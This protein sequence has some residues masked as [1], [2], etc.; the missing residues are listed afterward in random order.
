M[1]TIYSRSTLTIIA[2]TAKSVTEGFLGPRGDFIAASTRIPFLCR[3]GTLGTVALS[4]SAVS[5]AYYPQDNPIELRAWT[6][7][8]RLLA[9]R[10]L[11]YSND[12]IRFVCRSGIRSSIEGTPWIS[13]QRQPHY[14]EITKNDAQMWRN[15][16]EEYTKRS[17]SDPGDKLL[18]IAALA[19]AHAEGRDPKGG[20]LAGL[21]RDTIAGDL[22]WESLS[23]KVTGNAADHRT[24]SWSWAATDSRVSWSP[25]ISSVAPQSDFKLFETRVVPRLGHD[26]YG[27][28][29]HGH[30]DVRGRI[31]YLPQDQVR[32]LGWGPTSPNESAKFSTWRPI[33]LAPN[34]R[35]LEGS[36]D[37]PDGQTWI[38]G[39]TGSS[40]V[41]MSFDS[42]EAG[43]GDLV[44]LLILIKAL[45]S[46]RYWQHLCGLNL[47]RLSAPNQFKRVGVFE[48]QLFKAPFQGQSE[49]P[50]GQDS[51]LPVDFSSL[52]PG[53]CP[54][55][56]FD[57]RLGPIWRIANFSYRITSRVW[58]SRQILS[59]K[60]P[61]S[62]LT[63]LTRSCSMLILGL[64]MQ[65]SYQD[66]QGLNQ[67]M[68]F[69]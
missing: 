55:R 11:I 31:L 41:R 20:Y 35:I 54:C 23:E 27:Q 29:D 57:H 5:M 63:S 65:L 56:A 9:S 50:A 19:R 26:I 33:V 10:V 68:G 51:F 1:A 18:A 12:G 60:V 21:W 48:F 38:Q 8:E 43:R 69:G 67:C 16:V 49:P 37:R 6:Y 24:P 14:V 15:L 22:V 34:P 13:L 17:M 47:E 28:I 62:S 25:C 53:T 59:F 58:K 52:E 7:Q 2:A 3:D 36:Q 44:L 61:L 42:D 66:A 32:E 64:S 30:L 39:P 4:A 45:D 46:E 40:R